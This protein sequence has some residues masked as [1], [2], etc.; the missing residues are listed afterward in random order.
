MFQGK[1]LPEAKGEVVYAAS[2]LE[3]FAEEAKRVYGDLIPPSSA[4]QKLLAMKQPVG[5]DAVWTPVCNWTKKYIGIALM[6]FL[7]T[8]KL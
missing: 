6:K 3:W 4:S 5:V 8:S 1:V 2:F 7:S